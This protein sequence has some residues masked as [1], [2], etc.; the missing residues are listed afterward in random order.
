MLNGNEPVSNER[1]AIR[2]TIRATSDYTSDYTTI[3][4]TACYT[5]NE[6]LARRLPVSNEQRA[7]SSLSVGPVIVY[8]YYWEQ[9]KT[10]IS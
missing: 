10:I 2:A 8:S 7:T 5:S 4:A 9:P 3:R 1:L 6:R